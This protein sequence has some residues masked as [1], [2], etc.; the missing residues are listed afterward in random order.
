[1]HDARCEMQEA[2]GLGRQ[3]PELSHRCWLATCLCRAYYACAWAVIS[4][5]RRLCIQTY[6][7]TTTFAF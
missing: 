2:A 3:R 6:D 1:M 7:V 4:S 5:G